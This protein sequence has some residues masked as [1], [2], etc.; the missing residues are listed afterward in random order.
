MDKIEYSPLKRTVFENMSND[1]L[2]EHLLM[3]TNSSLGKEIIQE[4]IIRELESKTEKF[5]KELDYTLTH[6]C[7]CGNY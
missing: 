6:S 3:E 5:R 2:W 1:S 4:L 7:C